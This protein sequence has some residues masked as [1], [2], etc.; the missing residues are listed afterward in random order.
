MP[1]SVDIEKSSVNCSRFRTLMY[2][3]RP[4]VMQSPGMGWLTRPVTALENRRKVCRSSRFSFNISELWP[5]STPCAAAAA[6]A[7]ALAL[8]D[9]HT[10]TKPRL[11]PVR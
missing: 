9:A 7:A 3:S 5:L 6:I 10:F 11:Q 1:Y 8:C 2:P 4:A